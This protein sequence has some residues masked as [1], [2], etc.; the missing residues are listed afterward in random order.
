MLDFLRILR[1]RW[2]LVAVSAALALGTAMLVTA[3]T[4]PQYAASTTLVVSAP[5][6]A[7][8][9]VAAYQAVLL[10]QER[11]KSYARLIRSQDLA[12]RLARTLG[13]GVTGAELSKRISAEAVPGTVLLRATVRDGSPARAQGIAGALGPEFARFAA[14]LEGTG[15]SAKPAVKITVADGAALPTSQVSPRPLRNLA[16]GLL[17][18]L[19]AGAAAAA[20]R[21]VLDTA[22]R[23]GRELREASG[24][25]TIGA[26]GADARAAANR[27]VVR[28]GG[29]P[30]S[31]AFRSLRTNLWS[32]GTGRPPRSVAITSPVRGEGRTTVAANLAVALAD[33]GRRVVL[34]EG[35]LRRP[36]LA[37]WLGVEESEGLT[38]VLRGATTVDEAVRRWGASTLSVLPAGPVPEG[39]SEL[40]E[41][42]EMPRLL[43]ELGERA[44]I[45]IVDTPPVLY[46]TDAAII[47]RGCD[48]TLLL[49]RCGRTA[50]EEVEQAVE[51]LTA[52]G[53]GVLGAVLTFAPARDAERYAFGPAWTPDA[54]GAR[55]AGRSAQRT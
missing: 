54:R 3:W 30:G 29:S 44:D 25:T 34:V 39:P 53:A 51:R 12:D 16:V 26:I 6:D 40:L 46:V 15:G 43:R 18:G 20:L 55:V 47:A 27:L 36:R 49:A 48:A 52:A 37:A 22:V 21:D 13:D 35:D 23:C 8:N 41:S 38:G 50:R 1:R 9:P 17:A 33:A 28:D 19:L 42:E 2:I 11:A 10:S 7:G 31:E 14:G 5:A 45:V 32:T 24:A 4:T